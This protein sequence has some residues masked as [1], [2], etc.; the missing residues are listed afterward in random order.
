MIERFEPRRYPKLPYASSRFG[1]KPLPQ[2]STGRRRRVS[3]LVEQQLISH[4]QNRLG[5]VFRF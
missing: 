4:P 1:S 2:P 3:D 5:S